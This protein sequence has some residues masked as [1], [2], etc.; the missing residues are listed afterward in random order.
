MFC[1]PRHLVLVRKY[2][3]ESDS[4]PALTLITQP[5]WNHPVGLKVA[6][7]H[8]AEHGTEMSCEPASRDFPTAIL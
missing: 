5:P 2:T 3:V 8:L 6:L 4:T 1:Q 7:T